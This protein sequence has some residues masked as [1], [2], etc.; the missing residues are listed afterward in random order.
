ML[1]KFP[2]GQSYYSRQL[3]FY[4]FGVV[5]HLGVNQPQSKENIHVDVW[6]EQQNKKDNNMKTSALCHYLT[7]FDD[8]LT[9]C[10]DLRLFSDSC[11][12]LNKNIH[13]LLML[14]S[15][16]AQVLPKLNMTHTFPVRGFS[17]ILKQLIHCILNPKGR[18]K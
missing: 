3:Y 1:P 14:F 16:K 12:G 6:C 15:L 17:T 10:T 11:Y 2:I 7:L 18:L 13:L 8:D 5:C 4:I 9:K